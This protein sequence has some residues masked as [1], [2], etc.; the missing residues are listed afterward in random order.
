[1]AQHRREV[2]MVQLSQVT[3]AWR[4]DGELRA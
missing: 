2:A 4:Q 1:V 3:F